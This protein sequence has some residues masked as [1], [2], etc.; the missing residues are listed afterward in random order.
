M[1]YFVHAGRV[2]P[3]LLPLLAALPAHGQL[4][5][6]LSLG[7]PKGLAL[8][9]AVTADPPGIDSIHFNPAGLARIKGRQINLKLLV[10][11]VDVES[12]F[13]QPVKPTTEDKQ[14]YYD[15]NEQCQ[16]DYPAGDANALNQCWG[17]DPV[18]GQTTKSGD[19]V[20][21]IPFVGVQEV[22]I[23]AFPMGGMAFEDAKNN[24]VLGSAVYVPEG[25]GLTREE[26]GPGAYQ[27]RE[28]ALT[29]LTYF[30]PTIALPIGED[31]MVGLGINMSYQGLY[32]QT[33]FRAPTLTLGYIRDLNNIAGS[34]LPPIEF[35]PYDSAGLLTLEL[36]DMLS[37]GF[38]FGLLWEPTSWLALGFVYRSESKSDMSGDFKMENSEKFLHTTTGLSESPLVS[39]LIVGLGGAPLNAQAVEKGSVE[40]EYITPQNLAFGASIRV[41]PDL[42]LNLDLK[43]VEYSR[44]D[45]LVFNFD[46][47]VDFLSFGTAIS[48]AAGYNNTSPDT[49]TISR[50]YED[51]W[52][53][54]VGLEYQ[55]N[56]NWVAR[57]GYEPRTSSIPDDR[58]DLLF[59]L[60]EMQLYTAGL[61]WQFDRVTQ[62]DAAIAYLYSETSTPACESDNANS[63][64]EGNVVYNP[65]FSTPFENE[66]NGILVALSID[67]K[68]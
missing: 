35:G 21:M 1:R 56:A 9:N 13:G 25:I 68:F 55:L 11:Q 51:T 22:P 5:T 40:L 12:R 65:Y 16:T 26:D 37:V 50:Q 58:T 44:W 18:A 29:R 61:G 19:P 46:R 60:G 49:M 42:K 45:E 20:V 4:L 64:Q 28:V 30:S 38:N 66:V 27:G 52:S 63:C 23:L 54:A 31:L 36:E 24:W 59:P 7:N 53:W 15:V 6:N 10:A 32:V 34:P 2:L 47:D 41:L 62:I 17:V 39:G 8:G 57:V 43:W 33:E 67:R 3:V 14:V 48:R